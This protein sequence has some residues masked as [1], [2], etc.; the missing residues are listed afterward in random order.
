MEENYE[1]LPK[2]R[3]IARARVC[4]K[5]QV[6]PIQVTQESM[7]SS[8]VDGDHPKFVYDDLEE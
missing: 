3:K 4:P 1:D 2:K 7:N 5:Q 6:Q 8:D